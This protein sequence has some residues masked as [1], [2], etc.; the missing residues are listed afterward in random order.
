MPFLAY[1]KSR[2]SPDWLNDRIVFAFSVCL[3]VNFFSVKDFS[4]T[5]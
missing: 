2:F 5:T 3:S 4:G 1:A